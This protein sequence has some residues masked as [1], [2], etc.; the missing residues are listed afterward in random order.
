M[1]NTFLILAGMFKSNCT[2]YYVNFPHHDSSLVITLFVMFNIKK[3]NHL[4]NVVKC[5]PLSQCC[6]FLTNQRPL[7]FHYVFLVTLFQKSLLFTLFCT[8]CTSPT[9]DFHYH[10]SSIW[11]LLLSLK[12]D[13]WVLFT[14]LVRCVATQLCAELENF[15]LLVAV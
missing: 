14:T 4:A 13:F 10:Q 3:K 8:C 12:F 7:I 11:Y 15:W 5:N 1:K 9:G 6:V 2:L